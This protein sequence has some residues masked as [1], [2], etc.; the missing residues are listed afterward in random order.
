[1]KRH[2]TRREILGGLA[3][4]TPALVVGA[5]IAR[6]GPDVRHRFFSAGEGLSYRV[7]RALFRN[8]LAPEFTRAELSPRFPTNGNTAPQSLEYTRH[9]ATGFRDW[10]LTVR[11]LVAA[12]QVLSTGLTAQEQVELRQSQLKKYGKAAK[13]ISDQLKANEPDMAAIQVATA[14]L[15]TESVT[16]ETWFPEG[17]GPASGVDTDA[18]PTIWEM[19]DDFA[20]KMSNFRTAAIALNETAAGGGDVEAI[21]AA[22]GE[23]GGTCKACHKQYRK[24]D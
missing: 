24:D 22:F 7:H 5:A 3:V 15:V 17:S 8:T 21:K 4:A 10:A 18:L 2:T 6:G 13:T 23:T 11:G 12:P 14:S 16:M 1:M 20:K 9:A 19:P